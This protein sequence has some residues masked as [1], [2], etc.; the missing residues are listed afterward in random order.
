MIARNEQRCIE[1]CLTSVAQYVD[2]MIVLDTG[3]SDNTVD[4][5]KRCG[6]EVHSMCWPNS[7]AIA[8]NRALDLSDSDW[9]LVLDAD[10]WLISGGERLT[11]WASSGSGLGVLQ[12]QSDSEKTGSVAH[13]IT[14]LLPKGVRYEGA[15]HEQPVSTLTRTRLPVLV[16]HDG[17]R[18]EQMRSKRGRNREL[19]KTALSKQLDAYLLYQLGKDCEVY[20]DLAEASST[21][22]IALNHASPSESYWADL[23]VR[24]IYCLG[25]LGRVE[26]A[27]ELASE[28]FNRLSD[29]VNFQF[30]LG[31]VCLDGAVANPADALGHWLPLA[32]AAWRRCL[33]LGERPSADGYVE[34]RGG[35]LAAYNLRVLH[36][37][38]GDH[39]Q[40]SYYAALADS[41]RSSSAQFAV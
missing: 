39:R 41:L 12:I 23:S 34:G 28:V 22:A 15:I 24:A 2:K 18:D 1:R 14:R 6:A 32:E 4:I 19:L 3:S 10:E 7:F 21:Y 11:C 26:Q 16:G 33:E 20:G 36:D 29:D 13:W 38:L 37:G 17:Y 8:R 9:N 5:A 40:A 35:Y 31:D 27:L 30:T 25:K